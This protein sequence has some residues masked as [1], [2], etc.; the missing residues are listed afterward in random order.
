MGQRLEL[1][2]EAEITN[3]VRDHA[4]VGV[5]RHAMRGKRQSTRHK[6]PAISVASIYKPH[7]CISIAPLGF[8]VVPEV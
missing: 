1:W 7:L 2:H 6:I 4:I 8:P 3:Q 5:N